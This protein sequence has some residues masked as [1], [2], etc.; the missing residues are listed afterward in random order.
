MLQRHGSG[1][2]CRSIVLLFFSRMMSSRLGVQL[3]SAVYCSLCFSFFI[4]ALSPG[5]PGL[6]SC[7]GSVHQV[8]STHPM[9]DSCLPD[10]GALHA[11]S[12]MPA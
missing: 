1:I 8:N 4:E 11:D 12:V 9:L 6:G 7:R 2:N 5:L 3:C 10:R